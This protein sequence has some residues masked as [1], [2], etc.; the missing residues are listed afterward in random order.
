MNVGS[1]STSPRSDYSRPIK[2]PRSFHTTTTYSVPNGANW[3][4]ASGSSRPIRFDFTKALDE[5]LIREDETCGSAQAYYAVKASRGTN[6]TTFHTGNIPSNPDGRQLY[7][8]QKPSFAFNPDRHTRGDLDSMNK[9]L[10]FSH[11][12]LPKRKQVRRKDIH[13]PSHSKHYHHPSFDFISTSA[14][15][16]STSTSPSSTHHS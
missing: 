3:A 5:Q 16:H 10:P 6:T 9:A 11:A 12:P 2:T 7:Y 14:S 8:S 1:Y 4:Y 13:S 15:S